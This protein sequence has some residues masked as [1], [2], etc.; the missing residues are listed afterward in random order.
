VVRKGTGEGTRI[1]WSDGKLYVDRTAA[2]E[3]AFSPAFP[4]TQRVKVPLIDGRMRLRILVDRSS[5]EV[6]T[7]DG[8][9][10]ITN[11]IYP[12]LSSDRIAAYAEGGTADVKVVAR[13]VR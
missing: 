5:V 3:D 6:F 4:R 8:R 9:V 1:G 13:P 7:R 12:D 10:A 2:G 11:L